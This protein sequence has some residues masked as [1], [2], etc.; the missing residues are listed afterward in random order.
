MVRR[1]KEELPD[2]LTMEQAAKA[3]GI[4]RQGI[5]HAVNRGRIKALRFQHVVLIPRSALE[6][7]VTTKSK[8]GRPKKK[9]S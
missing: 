4:S 3:I 1:R 2:M 7:Y 6:E 5:W 9:T 8:G